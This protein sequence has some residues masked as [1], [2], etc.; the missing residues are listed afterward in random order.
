MKVI[1][2]N[3]TNIIKNVRGL[4]IVRQLKGVTISALITI[5]LFNLFAILLVYTNFEERSL[6]G[7]IYITTIISVILGAASVTRNKKG[8]GWFNG[9]MVGMYYMLALYFITAFI[10]DDFTIHSK[11][12]L[13]I[14]IG[15]LM[16]SLGGII[17]K[18]IR[19]K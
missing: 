13:T 14:F 19:L 12:V 16:G 2:S 4:L 8:S 5:F 3:R 9:G 10:V 6:N 11:M 18:N 7:S 17:G 1:T 15:M